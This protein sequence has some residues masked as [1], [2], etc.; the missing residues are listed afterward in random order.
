MFSYY[1]CHS[2]YPAY[3][4]WIFLFLTTHSDEFCSWKALLF[5]LFYTDNPY[6]FTTFSKF[7]SLLYPTFLLKGTWKPA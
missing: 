7:L 5:L 2:Y 3:L 1:Y 4:L 6:F